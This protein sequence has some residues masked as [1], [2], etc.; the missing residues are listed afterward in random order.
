MQIS[1][2]KN[3]GNSML[4]GRR[5]DWRQSAALFVPQLP[6]YF[7]IQSGLEFLKT[8]TTKNSCLPFIV[9]DPENNLCRRDRRIDYAEVR[10][11]W[12]RVLQG[13]RL[14]EGLCLLWRVAVKVDLNL[15]Q[16][17]CEKKSNLAHVDTYC[18]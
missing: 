16:R 15:Y 7:K 6:H 9:C 4:V 8:L 12:K 2:W 17:C 11:G 14:A 5:E 18:R 10:C 13:S 1:I 3:T